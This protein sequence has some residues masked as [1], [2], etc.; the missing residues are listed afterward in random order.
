MA[1]PFSHLSCGALTDVGVKRK[2]NEDS[3]VT[4][5]AHGVYCV[6]DGMGGAQGGEVASQAAVTCLDKAFGQLGSPLEIATAEGKAKLVD[7]ALNQASKWI[8][9]RSDKKGIRG[10][11]TTVVV[12]VYDAQDP[13]KALIVHA[14]DS[15][16]YRYRKGVIEQL[17]TDHTVAAAAGVTDDQKLPAMFRGVV[18]RAV[19]VKAEV[20]LEVTPVEVRKDDVYLLSSDGLDKLVPDEKIQEFIHDHGN[21]DLQDLARILVDETNRRGGVDNV[22]VILVRVG[23]AEKLASPLPRQLD[24]EID[25]TP[26]SEFLPAL[27]TDDRPTDDAPRS[28]PGVFAG[29]TP[30]LDEDEVVT[31][32]RDS[33]SASTP[34]PGRRRDAGRKHPRGS[35]PLQQ[36]TDWFR[37]NT[38]VGGVLSALLL[39]VVVFGL[40]N[41]MN[42]SSR[43]SR[44]GGNA[45]G[46]Q[47][48]DDG[49]YEVLSTSRKAS[50]GTEAVATE[51]ELAEAERVADKMLKEIEDSMRSPD[52]DAPSE[53]EQARVEQ[54]RLEEERVQEEARLE[55]ERLAAE[56]GERER[57]AVAQEFSPRV[58]ATQSS[59]RWGEL[60]AYVAEWSPRV[61]SLVSESGRETLYAAWTSTW[62]DSVAHSDELAERFSSQVTAAARICAA[63]G[64][65][66]P[67]A[68]VDLSSGSP[69]DRADA[70]CAALFEVQSGSLGMLRTFARDTAAQLEQFGPDPGTTLAN[71]WSI[72]GESDPATSDA[73][74]SQITGLRRQLEP[75]TQWADTVREGP[76]P[77]SA[78]ES[79]PVSDVE[80]VLAGSD[81]VR[82]KVYDILYRIPEQ[83]VVW[84]S[85]ED[86][87]IAPLLDTLEDVQYE[88][89]LDREDFNPDDIREWRTEGNQRLIGELLEAANQAYPLLRQKHEAAAR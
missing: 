28:V 75:I 54:E 63:G 36:F 85:W 17:S 61:G 74:A 15:R 25:E 67:D 60:A 43:S 21:G 34:E 41:L 3:I 82:R 44:S 32:S 73:V 71:L 87:A 33:R 46:L 55:Q 51:E 88:I 37:E 22:S 78:V 16:A 31:P 39:I 59:G 13:T 12:L 38:I 24:V 2:N 68:A 56:Q 1:N 64:W 27:D 8:K 9:Q 42:R 35:G 84:R 49:E 47:D 14:G 18:T 83:A 77:L 26:T 70:Y 80:A 81:E 86:D 89:V 7:R 6:A 52:G 57:E 20:E 53:A 48:F 76:V 50:E 4:L 69:E 23:E 79:A 65:P 11:G 30:D 5:P 10:A 66:P 19:G 29:R 72:S 62:N 45:D 58:D 40:M